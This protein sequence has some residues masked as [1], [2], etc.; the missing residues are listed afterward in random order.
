MVA[1]EVKEAAAAV[2]PTVKENPLEALAREEGSE[3]G[4]RK[5]AIRTVASKGANP[6]L[7]P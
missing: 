7:G 5:F 4:K 6:S 1:V 2:D 3:V